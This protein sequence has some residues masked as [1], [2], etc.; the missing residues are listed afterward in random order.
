MHFGTH[1]EALPQKCVKVLTAVEKSRLMVFPTG[2]IGLLH[3]S[4]GGE[5]CG[6]PSKT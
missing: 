2:P 1:L 4:E 5:V 3:T 6:V